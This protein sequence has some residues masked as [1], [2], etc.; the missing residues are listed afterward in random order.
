MIFVVLVC[1]EFV[2]YERVMIGLV[3]IDEVMVDF[4]VFVVYE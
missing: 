2:M 3:G 4:F 1:D